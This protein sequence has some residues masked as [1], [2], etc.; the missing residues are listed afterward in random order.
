[1]VLKQPRSFDSDDGSIRFFGHEAGATDRQTITR[2]LTHYYLFAAKDNGIQ[3]CALIHPLIAERIP[4]EYEG[5]T[6]LRGDTCGA[7]LSRIFRRFHRQ[8]TRDSATL[9]LTSVR[10]QGNRALA[11]M[12]FEQAP[13]PDH[14]ALHREGSTWKVWNLFAGQMP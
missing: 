4:E 7:V 1:M 10:V 8:L 6:E 3:A 9:E 5:N 2:L 11:L 14:M 13:V 12:R